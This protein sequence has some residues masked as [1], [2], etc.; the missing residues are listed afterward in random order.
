MREGPLVSV[1]VPCY[2]GETFLKEALKSAMAQSYPQV[3]IIVVDDGS[4]DSSPEIA[5]R[6]PV[7]YIRQQN[8]GL[9]EARNSGVRESKGSYLVFLDADDRLKPR[10]IETGLR[11][12]ELCPDCA[13][14]VGDHVF[15]SADGSYLANSCKVCPSQSHYEALLKS[16]FIEMISSV[17][18]RRS[19]FDELGGFDPTLRVAEDYELYLRI[20]RVRPICC[21]ATIAAE[22]RMHDA[23]TSR[24]SELMLTT[25]L[26]VLKRQAKYIRNDAGRLFAF[27][28][29][30]RS[31]RKQY[32]RQLAS[33][34][35]RS[36][37]TLPTDHLGRKLLLLAGQY[38]QGLLMLILLRML[39][40]LGRRNPLACSRQQVWFEA[41]NRFNAHRQRPIIPNLAPIHPGPLLE[42]GSAAR[43]KETR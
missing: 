5:Q 9:S 24:D 28:E 2:N 14:A 34:L 16:N 37:S 27:L 25:T 12:L 33:E 17:L 41:E 18:F 30:V 35:A 43:Q 20:A 29:G 7:R 8:R 1:I 15:I 32:G 31:W 40:A 19:I 26:Q 6:F 13:I 23:N 3:E 21:H 4:T 22:Y 36:F 38:P 42:K 39:P 11:M 10:A